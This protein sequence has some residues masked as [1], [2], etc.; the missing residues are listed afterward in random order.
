MATGAIMARAE[1]RVFG[2]DLETVGPALLVLVLAAV[3]SIVLP[4]IDTNTSYRNEVQHGDVVVLADGITLIPAAS[5]DLA[6][7]SIAGKTR[8]PIG[9]TAAT[10][11]V[12]G[13]LRLSVEA[14]PFAG[15][16]SSLLT[17][18]NEIDANL[19]DAK[20]RA[21][22]MTDRYAVTTRQGI[23]G[24]AEDF[25]GVA[26]EGSVIAFVF[27][28]VAR[29]ATSPR[30]REGVEVVVSGPADAISRKRGDIVAMIRSIR[31]AS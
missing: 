10:E 19:A 30:T 16:P 18:I 12:Q 27:N 25:V 28:P 2:L 29:S 21:A 13:G 15:T 1:R 9:S 11:L 26:R 8:S 31:A 17:R 3:M 4:S 20:G 24:V 14:A 6:S 7:G 22:E 5:W 23:V